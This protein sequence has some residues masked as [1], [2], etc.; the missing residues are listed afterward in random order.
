[1]AKIVSKA[2]Q[3][4]LEH[5]AKLGRK[6]TQIEVAEQ[7]GIERKALARLERGSTKRFDEEILYKLCVYYGVGVG[8]ILEYDPDGLLMGSCG[9]GSQVAPQL[10]MGVARA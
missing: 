4:R 3:L 2:L 8:D 6:I 9:G 1:M 5:Q 10:P 7:A